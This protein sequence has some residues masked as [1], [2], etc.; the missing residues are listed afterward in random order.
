MR[1]AK[2][3]QKTGCPPVTAAPVTTPAATPKRKGERGNVFLFILLGVVLFAALSYTMARGFRSEGTSKI[4]DRRAELAA[5]EIMDFSQRVSRAVNAMRAKNISENDIS[6]EFAGNFVNANC[7]DGAD[8]NY[9]ACQVFNPSGGRITEQAPPENAN[10]G[11]SWHF[12]GSSC[13]DSAAACASDSV[14]NEELLLV[15]PNLES[16]V[17]ES[18]NKKLGITGI[19]ASAASYSATAFTGSFSDNTAIVLAGGPFN[20]ACF[21]NGGNNHF[22]AILIER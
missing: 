9:P 15:L 21:S 19:P 22:Y 8:P 2:A 6:L 5:T 16:N 17:C 11:T 3:P 10:D 14:S 12:T 20:S 7:N 13:V 1:P 18:I 4:S